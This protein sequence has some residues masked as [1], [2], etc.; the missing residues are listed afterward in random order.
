MSSSSSSSSDVWGTLKVKHSATGEIRRVG[1]SEGEARAASFDALL[2]RV[3]RL[4][5][6][7][8]GSGGQ[9]LSWTDSDGDSITVSSDV[10]LREAF[11]VA[12][13]TAARPGSAL[14]RFTLQQQDHPI[15]A[16]QTAGLPVPPDADAD[17][18]SGADTA[19]ALEAILKLR[20]QEQEQEQELLRQRRLDEKNARLRALRAEA[21]AAAKAQRS[22]LQE[23][24]EALHQARDTFE[25]ARAE[26]G[27]AFES[28]YAS[29]PFG[30][31]VKGLENSA[32]RVTSGPG[33]ST[34]FVLRPN[35]RLTTRGG[36]DEGRWFATAPDALALRIP[37]VTNGLTLATVAGDLSSVDYSMEISVGSEG[38]NPDDPLSFVEASRVPNFDSPEAVDGQDD[39]VDFSICP[40]GI[41]SKILRIRV[42][43]D[44]EADVEGIDFLTPSG[45]LFSGADIGRLHRH[46]QHQ[47]HRRHRNHNHN[48]NHSH[49]RRG[50]GRRGRR[51]GG[52]GFFRGAQVHFGIICDVSEMN[53]IIGTRYHKIGHNYDLCE[54]EFQKLS[55]EEKCK[56]EIFFSH[57]AQPVPYGSPVHFG[58]ECDVTGMNPIHGPR[59]HLVG[60][61]YD[62]CEA[63]FKK[64]PEEEKCKYEIISH[65]GAKPVPYV[66]AEE[67]A[68]PAP[69]AAEPSR[70]P[71][72]DLDKEWV[73][74][75]GAQP[76]PVLAPEAEEEVPQGAPKPTPKPISEKEEKWDYQLKFLAS[77]G[78]THCEEY[79]TEL[80]ERRLGDV[81]AVINDI[82]NNEQ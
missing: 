34:V 15:P 58:V 47:H 22:A 31:L 41:E 11:D 38:G 14:I 40:P 49:N 23:K 18:D 71:S 12:A 64:L 3:A 62:L 21:L 25:A 16:S 78:F 17:A 46:R 45:F 51:C 6:A 37:G 27:R 74:V 70:T 30:A 52:P 33:A 8:P 72:P 28:L 39:G 59:F 77:I 50:C 2:A 7:A 1:V 24:S 53:P 81:N 20:A 80:L 57:G 56:F 19:A 61:N 69:E 44:L 63:E 68:P 65:R 75:D 48:H 42:P 9:S 32:F 60:A 4:F 26:R 67:P 29:G 55:E 35:G 43:A 10:E 66:T 54:A 5:G 13:R 36:G 79:L 73:A 76:Q 82:C